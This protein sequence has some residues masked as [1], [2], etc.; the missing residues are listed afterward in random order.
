MEGHMGGAKRQVTREG[1]NAR[2]Y[3]RG[4][5]ARA[6]GRGPHDEHMGASHG[7]LTP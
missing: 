6:H 3:G 2:A 4:P 5:N 1:P 7:G